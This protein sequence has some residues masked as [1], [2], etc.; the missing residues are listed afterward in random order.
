MLGTKSWTNEKGSC[1]DYV[2]GTGPIP[3]H[4][5]IHLSNEKCN[6]VSEFD[7]FFGANQ[8]IDVREMDYEDGP[9]YRAQW[10]TMLLAVLHLRVLLPEV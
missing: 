7:G 10:R 9:Q 3:L 8:S 4:L 1:A 6:N 5:K 2:L